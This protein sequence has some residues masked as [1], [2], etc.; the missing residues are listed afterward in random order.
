MIGRACSAPISAREGAA[1]VEIVRVTGVRDPA[2]AEGAVQIDE[3]GQPLRS[4]D[5]GGI[6]DA[7]RL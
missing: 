6:T 2:A 1:P 4:A 7:L 5:A 3:V